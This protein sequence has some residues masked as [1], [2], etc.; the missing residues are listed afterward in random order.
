[1]I[2]GVN[3]DLKL[4]LLCNYT[5]SLASLISEGYTKYRVLDNEHTR[6]RV[7]LFEAVRRVYKKS[8]DLLGIK[9]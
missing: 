3:N 5:Y 2:E 9:P 7:Q 4:N 8:F 6:T 1:M